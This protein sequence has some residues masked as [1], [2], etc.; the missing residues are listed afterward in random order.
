MYII[1]LHAPSKRQYCYLVPK[2]TLALGTLCPVFPSCTN[3]ALIT[4]PRRNGLMLF[5]TK[6]LSHAKREVP[7][8]SPQERLSPPGW[9]SP[10]LHGPTGAAPVLSSALQFQPLPF[11]PL[12]LQWL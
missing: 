1:F 10:L 5:N 3:P 2:V 7:I 11:C 4:N 12:A 8:R 9:F 6:D